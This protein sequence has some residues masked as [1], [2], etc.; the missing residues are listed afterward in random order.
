WSHIVKEIRGEDLVKEVVLE[1]LKTGEEK[2]LEVDGFFVALGA[3]PES[4]MA[5]ELG[6]EVNENG[7]I[8]TD[9]H[10]ATNIPGFFAAGD[11]VESMKQIAVAVGHGA[12]AADSAY[13]YIKDV[14]AS[15]I[16][17]YA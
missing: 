1:D 7:E 9:G 10:Q 4:K 3:S 5:I 6:V 2:V 11:V 12:I 15:Q 13:R 14:K 17:G 16:R 8:F